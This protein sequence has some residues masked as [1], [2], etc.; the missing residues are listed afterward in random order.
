MNFYQAG[1]Y[2]HYWCF[3]NHQNG[4]GIHSP[5]VFDLLTNI[6]EDFTPFYCFSDIENY[7]RKLLKN[8]SEIAVTDYGAGSKIQ[9]S[10]KRKI[11]EIARYS[12]TKPKYAQLLF[13]LVNHFKPENIIELGTSLGLTSLYLAFPN[14]KTK[15]FTVEGCPEIAKIASNTHSNFVAKNINLQIGNFQ[16]VLPQLL[17]EIKTIDFAFIDGNHSYKATLENFKLLKNYSNNNSIF[18]FDDI[19]WSKEMTDA[20]QE[21]KSDNAVTLSIDLFQFGIIFFMKDFKKQDFRVRF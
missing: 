20:W 11:S 8:H 4:H 19:Y 6:I 14:S 10:D 15:V 1:K 7:R 17:N 16:K 9:K 18:I 13:R 5:F 21:I 3:A 12:L 2:F